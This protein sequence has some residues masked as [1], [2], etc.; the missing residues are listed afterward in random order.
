ME[1]WHGET[2][3]NPIGTSVYIYILHIHIEIFIYEMN[4]VYIYIY[5]QLYSMGISG[6]ENGLIRSYHMVGH[7]LGGYSVTQA[8]NPG[9][10]Y[11]RYL[12]I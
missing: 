9:L 2:L 1:N 6:S 10:M 7:I 4:H 3:G 8:K 5:I 11:G 12:Q